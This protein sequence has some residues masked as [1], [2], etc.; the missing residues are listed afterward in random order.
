MRA[1]QRGGDHVIRL[2]RFEKQFSHEANQSPT[3]D[4]NE[5]NDHFF[6]NIV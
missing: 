2:L 5:C 3:A 1:R 6:F 4:Q